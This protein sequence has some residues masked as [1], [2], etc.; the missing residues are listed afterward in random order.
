MTTR[1]VAVTMLGCMV[2]ASG[3][4]KENR[5]EIIGRASKAGR[6]LNG[7]VRPNDVEHETPN[8]V[9]EQ[10][11]KERIKQNTQWTAENQAMHPIEY[12]QAQLEETRKMAERLDVQQHT[13]LVTKN[14][15]KRKIENLETEEKQLKAFLDKA[16][17]A[18]READAAD[19]FPMKLNGYDVSREK[20]QSA[21]VEANKKLQAATSQI[22]PNR[23]SLARIEQ[24][25]TQI[26]QEQRKVVAMREKLE[27]TLSDLKTKQ[28]IAG[29][30]GIGDALKA[31][32]D[33]MTALSQSANEP[34]S[35]DI[36]VPD[37][38]TQEKA[39]FDA[40]MAE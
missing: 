10:Q 1:L 11:R 4:S 38:A 23:N 30:K 34:D 8:I 17:A 39:E 21:I 25:L 20:A 3:C 36:M 35:L 9:A 31:L 13:L 27:M 19:A 37:A 18:Y 12:C 15:L 5:D 33:S 26:T 24:R 2:I 22:S 16:K 29:E 14:G 32:D 40:L 6:A 28:V 7:E